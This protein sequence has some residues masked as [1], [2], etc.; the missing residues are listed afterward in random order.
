MLES[1]LT[2][3]RGPISKYGVEIVRKNYGSREL[4]GF[5]FAETASNGLFRQ[6]ICEL[7]ELCE[8]KLSGSMC[9]T[10]YAYF[11]L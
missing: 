7:L 9:L 1:V 5:A 6:L 2:S 10:H 8:L 11:D 3:R 4:T